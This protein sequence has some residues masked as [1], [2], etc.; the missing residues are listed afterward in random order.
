[1]DAAAAAAM[2]DPEHNPH[3]RR[4]WRDDHSTPAGRQHLEV[5][6]PLGTLGLAL[7]DALCIKQTATVERRR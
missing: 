3:F 7:L 2:S 6:N 4:R 1:M 5:P